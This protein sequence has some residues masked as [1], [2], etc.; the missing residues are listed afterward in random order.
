MEEELLMIAKN[1]MVLS[2]M[3]NPEEQQFSP[4]GF[5]S[6]AVYSVAQHIERLAES[7]GREGG[8]TA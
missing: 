4:P 5:I 8:E 2:Q 1:L 3:I 6:D 7:V